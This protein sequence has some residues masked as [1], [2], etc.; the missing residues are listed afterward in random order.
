MWF[1]QAGVVLMAVHTD[2]PLCPARFKSFMQ[3]EDSWKIFRFVPRFLIFVL[4]LV[5][6]LK[7]RDKRFF[8][9]LKYYPRKILSSIIAG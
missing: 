9:Y 8:I 3:K 6:A 5:L 7:N 1:S 4:M 2:L